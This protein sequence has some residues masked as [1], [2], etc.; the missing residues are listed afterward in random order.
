[1][2]CFPVLSPPEYEKQPS[3]SAIVCKS[4]LPKTQS[5]L[6][7][8]KKSPFARSILQDAL[9]SRD[10]CTKPQKPSRPPPKTDFNRKLPG[11]SLKPSRAY[12]LTEAKLKKRI[13]I[14][15]F[16][17]KVGT[18]TAAEK[19]EYPPCKKS[20]LALLKPRDKAQAR[21]FAQERPQYRPKQ[22]IFR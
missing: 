8:K 22:R 13:T 5:L 7:R 1:M 21:P 12:S 16:V 4:F 10:N 19:L 2:T 11:L 6:R 20:R 18:I 3:R 14:L 15:S 17:A 9:F